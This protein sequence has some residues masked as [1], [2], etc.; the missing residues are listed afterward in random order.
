MVAGLQ[1]GIDTFLS[2]PIFGVIISLI[3]KEVCDR[4]YK[5]FL[6]SIT[7]ANKLYFL[8]K[9]KIDDFN[10]DDD[11]RKNKKPFPNNVYLNDSY[12]FPERWIDAMKSHDTSKEFTSKLH[13]GSNKWIRLIFW[14]LVGI[15]IFVILGIS[16]ITLVGIG[17]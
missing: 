2:L 8:I 9:D 16:Y 10:L 6:E 13:S 4:F 14:I 7:V 11:I 5:R 17:S 3:G 12:L 15:N 1:T